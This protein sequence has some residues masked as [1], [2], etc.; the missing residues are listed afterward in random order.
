MKLTRRRLRK[1]INE[2]ILNEMDPSA[3][4]ATGGA[5]AM[6]TAY[7]GLSKVS[8]RD[9]AAS[10]AKLSQELTRG[11]AS[12]AFDLVSPVEEEDLQKIQAQYEVVVDAYKAAVENELSEGK[13]EKGSWSYFL[14]E[15]AMLLGIVSA[16]TVYAGATLHLKP[17]KLFKKIFRGNSGDKILKQLKKSGISMDDPEFNRHYE[18]VLRIERS[19]RG[20]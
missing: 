20:L 5:A 16:I 6:G 8:D 2:A 13:G 12:I 10:A 7:S 3:D 1:L 19:K 17:L 18:E 9:L 4:R 14:W 11:S 15:L